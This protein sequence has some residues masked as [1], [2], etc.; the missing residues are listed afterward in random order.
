MVLPLV[1]DWTCDSKGYRVV[2]R[3]SPGHPGQIVGEHPYEY[4]IIEP[5]GGEPIIRHPLKVPDLYLRFSEIDSTE[6]LLNFVNRF[7]LL[8]KKWDAWSPRGQAPSELVSSVLRSAESLRDLIKTLAAARGDGTQVKLPRAI[9]IS[10]VLGPKRKL[11]F[12]PSTLLWG[13]WLQAVTR[14]VDIRQCLYCETY[15]EVGPNSKPRRRV[16]SLYCSVEHQ[17]R[18][19]SLKRSL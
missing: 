14:Q 13:L 12:E 8:T 6:A 19:K 18:D 1:L 4:E 3:F 5:L 9:S 7:G 15:F 11:Q 17:K 2:R 16:D 10:L